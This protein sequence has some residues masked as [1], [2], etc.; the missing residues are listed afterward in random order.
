MAMPKISQATLGAISGVQQQ[1]SAKSFYNSMSDFARFK[2]EKK[3]N[4]SMQELRDLQM[5]QTQLGMEKTK[6][7]MAQDKLN[8]KI[9]ATQ[10]E[11]RQRYLKNIPDMPDNPTSADYTRAGEIAM[12]NSA[13]TMAKHYFDMAKAVGTSSGKAG[14]V[15]PERQLQIEINA[16]K[17]EGSAQSLGQAAEL[18]TALDKK[19]D[20]EATVKGLDPKAIQAGASKLSSQIGA[21]DAEGFGNFVASKINV[22]VDA[23]RKKTGQVVDATKIADAVLAEANKGDEA[24]FVEGVVDD[25]IDYEKLTTLINSTIQNE[26]NAG[27]GAPVIVNSVAEA[28]KLSKGTRFTLNGRTGTVQ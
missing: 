13:P 16:L 3:Q 23:L 15:S 5:A 14:K 26:I 4:E 12:Q 10:Y 11:T 24:S 6:Y 7:D 20:Q 8:D 27:T 22:A 1:E 21:G 2:E 28:N 17:N 19:K 18:Q 9:A 25:T